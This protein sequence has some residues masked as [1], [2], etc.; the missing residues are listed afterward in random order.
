[1]SGA[2]SDGDWRIQ[3]GDSSGVLSDTAFFMGRKRKSRGAKQPLVPLVST[4]LPLAATGPLDTFFL[5]VPRQLSAEG[6]RSSAV[7]QSEVLSLL[8]ASGGDLSSPGSVWASKVP[9]QNISDLGSQE[10]GVEPTDSARRQ[11]LV[12]ERGQGSAAPPV[13]QLTAE[14]TAGMAKG[15]EG[16]VP[17]HSVPPFPC[18]WAWYWSLQLRWELLLQRHWEPRR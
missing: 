9:R 13:L 2:I 6:E 4:P 8:S 12:F 3:D 1:M 14:A 7:Q 10:E 11:G 5:P 17:C 15:S 18:C 16:F